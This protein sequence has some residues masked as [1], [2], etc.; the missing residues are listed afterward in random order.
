MPRF[1]YP[2]CLLAGI[3]ICLCAILVRRQLINVINIGFT[4]T[5]DLNRIGSHIDDKIKEDDTRKFISGH[6]NI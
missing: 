5:E 3:C 4:H 2:H 6:G 1:K